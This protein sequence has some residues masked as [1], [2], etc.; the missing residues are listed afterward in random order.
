MASLD[1]IW[2]RPVASADQWIGGLAGAR[3]AVESWRVTDLMVRRGLLFRSRVLAP[4]DQM[5]RCDPEAV[6]LRLTTSDVLALPRMGREPPEP[7]TVDLGPTTAVLMENGPSLRLAGLRLSS[8]DSQLETLLVRRRIPGPRPRLIPV[9]AISEIGPGHVRVVPEAPGLSDQPVYRQDSDIE[10]DLWEALRQSQELSPVDAQGVQLGV[11]SGAVALDGNVRDRSAVALVRRL[12]G[13]VDGVLSVDGRLVNDWDLE[14]AVAAV[15]GRTDSVPPGSVEVSS[16]LGTVGLRGRV[17]S[18]E[19]K[20][21]VLRA[22]AAVEGVRFLEDRLDV[23]GQA[24][25]VMP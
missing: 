18:S 21:A 15:V 19:A 12:V 4:F 7:T 25:S 17:P 9:S 11:S 20:E 10:R 6:Y 14:L 2:G 22:A 23:S 5:R 24:E 13:A 1:L 8:E 16:H 3:V